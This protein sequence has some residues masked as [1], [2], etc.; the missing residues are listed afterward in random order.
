MIG[1]FSGDDAVEIGVVTR[2]G[3]AESR[4]LGSAVVLSADGEIQAS[5]G[6]PETPVYPRSA[7]KPF[8][9]VAV[10]TSGVTLRGEDAA[11]ITSSHTGTALHVNRVRGVLERFGLDE[12]ALLCPLMLPENADASAHVLRSGGGP[13]PITHGCS[14]KHAGLLAACVV[15]E[16]PTHS[17]LEH[18]HP[19]QVRIREV[20]ERLT[21]ERPTAPTGDGCGTPLYAL[22]LTGL[23]RG[24]Q[25]VARSTEQSP[26][27]L[28]REAGALGQAIRENP[29]IIR[30]P[31]E[32][33][34][35]AIERLGVVS[36]LG[37][38]GV[39]TMVAPN[40]TAVALKTLD[41]SLR[42]GVPVAL[43]LLAEHGALDHAAVAETLD[44]VA[45]RFSAGNRLAGRLIPSIGAQLIRA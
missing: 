20:I 28:H 31:G 36:K 3:F 39:Q 5:Y 14:G 16:W 27:A 13:L 9:A 30:G 6:S 33:E 1:T 12:R 44:I 7:L 43:A 38:E 34:S 24:M 10:L 21:G 8:I 25:R 4:H 32:P 26:F 19:L 18:E 11:I 42:P 15:N 35:I 37:F 41:G 17:Y 29:V 22:S 45:P 2:D 23:A 40:G